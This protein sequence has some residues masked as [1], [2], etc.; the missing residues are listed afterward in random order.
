M[1]NSTDPFAQYIVEFTNVEKGI[2][3]TAV[4]IPLLMGFLV[5]KFF[6]RKW[7]DG[8]SG[9]KRME[10]VNVVTSAIL[11]GTLLFH[12]IPMATQFDYA[13]FSASFIVGLIPYVYLHYMWKTIQLNPAHGIG[14]RSLDGSLEAMTATNH[15]DA[16]EILEGDS[17]DM[18]KIGPLQYEA[19]VAKKFRRLVAFTAFFSLLFQSSLDVLFMMYNPKGHPHWQIILMFYID[20]VLEST[21]MC[22]VL[23]YARVKTKP[24]IL[25][26]LFYTLVVGIGCIPAVIPVVD[27]VVVV[28]SVRHPLLALAVGLSAG[29]LIY[30][31]IVFFVID[32]DENPRKCWGATKATFFLIA[33]GTSWVTGY[34]V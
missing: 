30:V 7:K 26:I 22:A 10:L 12:S 29:S 18:D 27:P 9:G 2:I 24:Y 21:V 20:K 25:L 16:Y 5:H 3:P 13:L 6:N 14:G 28:Y 11:M 17:D 15:G 33:I 34:W 31:T 8:D 19:R 32:I 1:A 4:V 23:T